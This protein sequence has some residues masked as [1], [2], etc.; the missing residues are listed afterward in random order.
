MLPGNIMDTE[1]VPT[2]RVDRE[3]APSAAALPSLEPKA[4]AASTATD[5]QKARFIA[6][7]RRVFAEMHDVTSRKRFAMVMPF[8]AIVLGIMLFRGAPGARVW[9]QIAAYGLSTCGYVLI[10]KSAG[11]FATR[12]RIGLTLSLVGMLASIANT[13]GLASP[14]LLMAVPYLFS[15]S[16]NPELEG[17]RYAMLAGFL[18]GLGFMAAASHSPIG[19]I[20]APLGRID[21]RA[22]SEFITLALVAGVVSTIAC[23]KIGMGISRAYER[24]AL[25]LDARREE[26]CDE[27]EGRTRAL[28]GIAARLA[29]EVKNP[30]AAIKGLSTHMARSSND[31]KVKERLTIVAGEAE[32]LQDIVDGFL[33]FSRGLDDLAIGPTKPYDIAR[34]LGLLLETRAADAG[35]SIEVR[36]S[37]ELSLN[38]D[39][40]KLRQALLNLVLNAMQASARGASVTLEIAKSYAD[41]AAHIKVIDHGAGMAPEVIERIRKPYFTTKEGGSGLGIAVAR[42]II[43][44]HGG[45]LRFDSSIGRGTTATVVLPACASFAQALK[46]KLPNP[47]RHEVL[48]KAKEAATKLPEA[49][50]SS[51]S[52]LTGEP[53]KVPS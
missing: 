20:Y 3:A 52:T 16:M 44:Q 37:R 25:E 11:A 8:Q 14:L 30:L 21:G 1:L 35:V 48:A 38:A 41:G 29:H 34:E 50:P 47:C 17:S 10:E 12:I 43:E 4:S 9:L 51:A 26:L 6:V 15:V 32:R 28:E 53:E 39:T 40:R 23:V 2:A 24:I 46:A 19:E 49:R 36:G 13:G 45:T 33:S 7:R 27:S 31:P 5:R 42:G 22:S 18:G